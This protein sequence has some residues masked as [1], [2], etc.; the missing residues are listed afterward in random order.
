VE[1]IEKCSIFDATAGLIFESLPELL[2]G[3]REI[4]RQIAK[5]VRKK[6]WLRPVG[7]G[8]KNPASLLAI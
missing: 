7:V 8:I 6:F 2:S 4:L 5:P 1:N 3:W